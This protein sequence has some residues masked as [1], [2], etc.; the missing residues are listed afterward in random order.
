M[1]TLRS[2]LH[3]IDWDELASLK[4]SHAFYKKFE[5][6]ESVI[7]VLALSCTW[8]RLRTA[9]QYLGVGRLL[10][11]ELYDKVTDA[12]VNTADA[13]RKYY[14]NKM[15][16]M[17]IQNQ[18]LTTFRKDLNEFVNGDGKIFKDTMLPLAY[19]LPEFYHYDRAIDSLKESVNV[20]LP[21]YCG[22]TTQVLTPFVRLTKRSSNATRNS[23]EYWFKNELDIAHRIKLLYKNPL[24]HIWDNL[25]DRGDCMN[26]STKKT[27]REVLDGLQFV[28]IDQWELVS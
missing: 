10:D 24:Q 20:V 28:S 27:S 18:N 12:D 4:P 13:V 25:F 15:L 14:R 3:N 1:T 6:V 5:M 16:V 17:V 11:P 23:V 9:G 2:T 21:A 19:R 8:Y 22:D 26:I 7:D